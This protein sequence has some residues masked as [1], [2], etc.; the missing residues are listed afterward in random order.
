MWRRS[1]LRSPRRRPS[2]QVCWGG[3]A[4]VFL[5]GEQGVK[6]CRVAVSVPVARVQ[7][8]L[9]SMVMDNGAM[10]AEIDRCASTVSP[11][12]E[13]SARKPT[14]HTPWGF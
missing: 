8:V 6:G 2:V 10:C 4:A 14:K 3:I 1:D 7:N 11:E 5:Q 12:C 9:G 13:H